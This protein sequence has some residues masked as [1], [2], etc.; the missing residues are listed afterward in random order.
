MLVRPKYSAGSFVINFPNGYYHDI[1]PDTF[2]QPT[3]LTLNLE[4]A[5]KFK[6]F[7]DAEQQA[8]N[9]IK[10]EPSLGKPLVIRCPMRGTKVIF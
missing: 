10:F 1:Q 2:D 3:N 9:I 8:K 6:Y 4:E 5:A 7:C